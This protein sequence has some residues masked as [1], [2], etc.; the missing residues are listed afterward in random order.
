MLTGTIQPVPMAC[1]ICG[2][3]PVMPRL[4]ESID[5]L[6]KIKIVEAMWVCSRCGAK[7]QEGIVSQEPLDEKK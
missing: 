6:N 4:S 2:G 3:P 7:I 5:R 1:H